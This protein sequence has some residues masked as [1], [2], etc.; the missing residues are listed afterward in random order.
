MNWYVQS[1]KIEEVDFSGGLAVKDLE[2]PLMWLGSLLCH[3]LDPWPGN[4]SMLCG[5]G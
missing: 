5:C 1:I 4:L 3:R 2:L